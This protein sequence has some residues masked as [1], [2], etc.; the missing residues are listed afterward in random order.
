MKKILLAILLIALASLALTACGG[1]DEIPEGMKLVAGGDA[2]GYYFYGPEEWIT[3]NQKDVACTYVSTLDY[4]SVTFVKS[5][6]PEAS[7]PDIPEAVRIKEYFISSTERLN[8]Y[9]FSGFT[10]SEIQGETCNFGNAERAY[11]FVYDYSYDDIPYCEKDHKHEEKHPPKPYK[12]M[13]ILILNGDD[14][15]IFTYNASSQNYSDDD[16][17][18]YQ[19][20]L[21]NKVQPIIE[22]FKFVDKTAGA[23]EASAP[24][25]DE[26]GYI[27]VSDKTL[28]G[29][30]LYVTPAY[31]TDYS[32]GI[33]SVSR[34]DGANITASVLIDATISIKDNYITRKN[35]L[36]ALADKASD[37]TPLFTEIKGVKKNDEGEESLHIIELPGVRSAAEFEYKYTI[38]GKEYHTYQVFTVNGY[39][40]MKAFVFTFTCPEELYAERIAEAQDILARMEY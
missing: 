20:Y 10:L 2:D 24:T 35:K 11:K 25:P 21:T 32:S 17:S 31:K 8:D 23:P 6:L 7:S 27:L 28:S 39:M 30:D 4:T 12:T 15:Y 19:F 16:G 22:N 9:P 34:D 38:L 36:T 29:F 1:G 18:Y 14:F 13:Q 26:D 40:D 5:T 33:V 37:G 3:A